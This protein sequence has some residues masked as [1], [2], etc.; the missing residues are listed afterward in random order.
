[1][2]ALD[3]DANSLQVFPVLSRSQLGYDPSNEQAKLDGKFL[4]NDHMDHQ[5][6][7]SA[8]KRP[9]LLHDEETNETRPN[10]SS[11]EPPLGAN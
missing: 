2:M 9:R 3:L 4:P 6:F 1:M 11:T 8:V 7:P 10:Y 5:A